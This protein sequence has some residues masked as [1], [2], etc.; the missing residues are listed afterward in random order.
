MAIQFKRKTTAAGAPAGGSLLAGELALNTI[1]Q[2]IYTSS[3]GTDIVELTGGVGAGTVTSVNSILPDGAGN[4]L[5]GTDEV[6]EGSTNFYYTSGRF[7]TSF[8][9]KTTSDLGEGTNL[10]FT[11][12]RSIAT[13]DAQLALADTDDLAEGAG[14]LYYTDARVNTYVTGTLINDTGPASSSELYSSSKIE[15]LIAGTLAYKG[16]WDASANTPTLADGTGT[17]NDWYKVSV[18][19]TQDLGSGSET[20]SVGDDVIHNGT[21][22][23]LFHSVDAVDSVNGKIGVVVL[24]SDDI[25]EGTTN[26][27]YT[28]ART[29]ADVANAGYGT[30]D[31]GG[32]PSLT[33]VWSSTYMTGLL[34]DAIE[35]DDGASL[36]STTKTWSINKL[37]AEF[38]P[39]DVDYGTYV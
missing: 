3:D 6:I 34:G 35:I 8:A 17:A 31:D 18:A 22:W 15:S 2:I 23:E 1:D 7:D 11:E 19:G 26:L 32:V 33:T 9:T 39:L 16:S 29:L 38:M 21:V 24:D 4:V 30:I 12:L 28:Q 27:Y 37:N 36:A 25:A 13:F 5:I 14:S 20:Y 10:Y